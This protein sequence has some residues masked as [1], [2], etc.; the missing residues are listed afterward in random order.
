MAMP[1]IKR[2]KL[3]AKWSLELDLRPLDINYHNFNDLLN[4]W[5]VAGK[6]TAFD[7]HSLRHIVYLLGYKTIMEMREKYS[8]EDKATLAR[9]LN[10]DHGYALYKALLLRRD[11][12][13]DD[14]K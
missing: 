14:N 12:Q 9:L 11:A 4:E 13:E 2:G 3:A 6:V 5:K 8:E 10:K 1:S 7:D